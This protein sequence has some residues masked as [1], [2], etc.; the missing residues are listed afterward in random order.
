MD[1]KF[2]F[3]V[4]IMIALNTVVLAMDTYDQSMEQ[5]AFLHI[6]NMV[7]TWLFFVEMVMKLVGL[8]PSLYNRDIYNVF[9]AAVVI[10]SL[11][12]FTLD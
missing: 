3:F 2:Q 8:G 12:D 6:A 9:D 5:E 11:V 4:T 1:W 7:F 10:L